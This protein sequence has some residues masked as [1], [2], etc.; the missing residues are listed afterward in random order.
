MVSLGIPMYM[1]TEKVMPD[2]LGGPE[3]MKK[4][5]FGPNTEAYVVARSVRAHV[6]S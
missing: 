3:V 6:Q 4:V 1:F 5:G 2:Y